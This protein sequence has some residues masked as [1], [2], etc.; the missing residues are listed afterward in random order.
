MT[1]EEFYALPPEQQQALMKQMAQVQ[2]M[3]IDYGAM[4]NPYGASPQRDMGAA[5]QAQRQQEQQMPQQQQQGG[6][7]GGI[8][9]SQFMNSGAAAVP[10]SGAGS[11]LT[12]T[13]AAAFTP[14]M[15]PA[16]LA[17]GE[18]AVPMMGEAI[19]GNVG[20]GSA[21]AGAAGG[22]GA[23]SA[24]GLGAAAV[25]AAVVAAIVANE[26]F[27]TEDGRRDSNVGQSM[28]DSVTGKNMGKDMNAW[29]DSIGGPVG[30]VMGGLGDIA[31]FDKPL[32]QDPE[33][34]LKFWEWF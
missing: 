32:G 14:A 16:S 13:E 25:P 6:G 15:A 33:D 11:A 7:G 18:A 1:E 21:S 8:N 29:G 3:R 27:A 2:E 34:L 19:A 22:S 24:A 9:P 10:A 28:V 20:A 12:A 30:K 31:R 23:G 4:D 26:Y 17:T 5:P